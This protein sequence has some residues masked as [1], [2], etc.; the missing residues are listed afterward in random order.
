MLGVAV[1]LAL[2]AATVALRAALSTVLS[3]A[4]S[5]AEI[6]VAAMQEGGTVIYLRHA[7][8]NANEI[9][10]GRLGDRAGQ[11]NLSAAGI[12]QA[13]AL[14]LAFRRLGVPLGD[15]LA[16]PVF[17][18]R[19]T[20]ELAFGAGRITV[21]MDLVADDY[22]GSELRAMLDGSARLLR[23]PPP[24]GTNRLLIGHRTPLQM[25]TGSRFP[26]SVL[27]G[28]GDGRL[29]AR[30]HASP[31]GH[32]FRG[33]ADRIGRR[34][35]LTAASR[36]SAGGQSASALTSR[37]TYN[38]RRAAEPL[39]GGEIGFDG[40]TEAWDACRAPLTR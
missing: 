34:S 8:T 39:S 11:R 27:P 15:I 36:P 9:D 21:T 25:V 32:D 18:A 12:E 6:L 29:S 16:S 31:A 30:R 1:T 19:D 28:R 13:R 20:A 37:I 4:Q 17:R 35:P 2:S 24:P 26:D 33:A 3:A 5:E 7:A 10:T 38:R 40:G 14:G 23:T 22:A